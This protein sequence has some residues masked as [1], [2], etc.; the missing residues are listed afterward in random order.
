MQEKLGEREKEKLE[1]AK[2]DPFL[3]RSFYEETVSYVTD[4]LQRRKT[5]KSYLEVQWQLNY[6]FLEGRQYS[7]ADFANS[8][9][10]EWDRFEEGQERSV[11]NEI[12]PIIETRR[13][14]QRQLNTFMSVISST[15]ENDDIKN[16][17]ITTQVLQNTY[18]KLSFTAKLEHAINLSET[19]GTVLLKNVWDNNGGEL[20]GEDASGSLLYEGEILC[21]VISPFEFFP[22]D[23]S[24]QTLEEQFS[25]IHAKVYSRDEL[26]LLYGIE[27]SGSTNSVYRLGTVNHTTGNY[28]Y[29]TKQTISLSKDEL[30]DS[31]VLI[32]Y[33]ER[34]SRFYPEGRFI[35]VCEDKLLEYKRELPYRNDA[36]GKRKF[37]FVKI[38]CISRVN[39]FFGLSV[40]ERLIPIQQEYNAVHNRINEYLKMTTIGIPLI[41]DG[42]LLEEDEL[43]EVGFMP[44]VPIRYERGSTPP[45][46]METPTLPATFIN[47]LQ[48]LKQD[49]IVVSGVSEISRNSTTPGALTSGIGIQLL[50]QQDDT[51]MSLSGK[52]ILEALKQCGTQWLYLYKEFATTARVVRYTGMSYP[53]CR[54]WTKDNLTS[55]DIVVADDSNMYSN[56]AL[57]RELAGTLFAQGFFNGS[58]F[59]RL[60]YLSLLRNGDINK[61]FQEEF[62]DIKNAEKENYMFQ[63]ENE[64]PKVH[65]EDD[66]ELHLKQHNILRKSDWYRDVLC[67]TDNSLAE[68]FDAHC[69]EHQKYL[70]V[71]KESEEQHEGTI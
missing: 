30:K 21:D 4:E 3:D 69:E 12:A 62:L 71:P 8:E 65:A 9:T 22:D 38:D 34:P 11:H 31:A 59:E 70:T 35:V 32:E 48:E 28:D 37:P 66:H 36:N 49:F 61:A 13:A 17:E 47:K 18:N 40:I 25:V 14:K 46:F 6:D 53:I 45:R 55:F 2:R 23:L 57:T 60:S 43:E 5:E 24:K 7:M 27:I 58:R 10:I 1:E 54:K 15:A 56:T 39:S 67:K 42:S 50:Q 41:E 52:N 63:E 19:L 68:Q 33:Y 16:A 64:I 44:G 20:V 51:R 29:G 26:F